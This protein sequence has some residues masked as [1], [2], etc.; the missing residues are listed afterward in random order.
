MWHLGLGHNLLEGIFGKIG[1]M[2]ILHTINL[3]N[4]GWAARLLA[5]LKG[6]V[7][8]GAHTGG[9]GLHCGDDDEALL[10]HLHKGHILHRPGTT[11][12][13]AICDHVIQLMNGPVE[14]CQP[15]VGPLHEDLV[16]LRPGQKLVLIG[17]H[18]L[19]DPIQ[20]V[21]FLVVVTVAPTVHPHD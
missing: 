12:R 7:E 11:S 5:E 15:E 19:L 17:G 13:V 6:T 3:D 2:E 1:D 8:L 4:V 21:A 14:V 16:Q 20:A 9:L 10:Q 18:L